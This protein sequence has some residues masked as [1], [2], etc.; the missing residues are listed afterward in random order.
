VGLLR[1]WWTQVLALQGFWF[2]VCAL[3][4]GYLVPL[5]LFPGAG[6]T[7]MRLLPLRALQCGISH[8]FPITT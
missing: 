2:G 5:D 4:S 6:G 1:F 7:G 3:C 8:E